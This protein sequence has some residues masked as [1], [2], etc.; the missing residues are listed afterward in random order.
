MIGVLDSGVG[1]LS[2]YREIKSH[3]PGKSVVY[4]ADKKNFPYGEKTEEELTSI[5]RIA[6]KNLV[7]MGAS[8]IVIACNSATVATV[9]QIRQ[10]FDVP[11]VGIEPAVKLAALHSNNGKIGVLATKRTTKSHEGDDLAPDCILFKDHNEP[12][13]TKIENDYESITDLDLRQAMEPFTTANVDSIVL[14]CTH[15][16]FLK[17]RL[18]KMFPNIMFYAPDEAVVKQLEVVILQNKVELELGNDIFL[19]S[20]EP[21]GFRK[22]L[23]NLLG[24]K[25]ADIREI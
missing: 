24:I 15:Y 19:C 7:D 12:L 25:D 21:D 13:V 22:S 23:I 2:I 1:G 10:E 4:F 3:F 8:I 16:H 11:I 18:E 20:V 6:V 5:V 14:G 9:E 17:D